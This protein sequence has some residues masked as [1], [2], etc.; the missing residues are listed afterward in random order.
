LP[1]RSERA[2]KDLLNLTL[3]GAPWVGQP[4]RVLQS[5]G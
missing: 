4:A 3:I 5:I 1:D 2:A